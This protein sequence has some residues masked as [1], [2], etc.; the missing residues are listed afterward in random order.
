MRYQRRYTHDLLV[1]DESDCAGDLCQPSDYLVHIIDKMTG[2]IVWQNGPSIRY[3]VTG[4]PK[5]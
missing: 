5:P 2:E 1:I 4:V 3:G